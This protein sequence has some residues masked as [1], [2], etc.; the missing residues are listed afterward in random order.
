MKNTNE[1]KT[2]VEIGGAILTEKAID[3]LK[4]LQNSNNENIDFAINNIN[5][6]IRVIIRNIVDLEPAELEKTQSILV[7]MACACDWIE[8]LQKP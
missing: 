1:L 3:Q 2:H 7:G 5:K 4:Q 6:G 8:N